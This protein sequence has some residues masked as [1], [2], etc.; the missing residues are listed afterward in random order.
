MALTEPSPGAERLFAILDGIGDRFYAVDRDWLVTFF[1]RAAESFLGLKRSDVLGRSLWE[2]FPELDGTEIEARYRR[3]MQSRSDE[4]FE[5]RSTVWPDHWLEIRVFATPE[6]LGMSARD[7]TSR[8]QAEDA[9]RRSE[10]KLR[11]ALAA[12][13]LG[14]WER[15]LQTGEFTTTELCKANLGLPADAEL[16]FDDLQRMRHPEDVGRVTSAIRNAIGEGEDYDVEYRV[17]W[18]DGSL[19]WLLA[20]GHAVY[21]GSGRPMRMVG[22]TLDVTN[23]KQAEAS[24][25][26]SE[27]FKTAILNASLDGIVTIDQDSRIVEWNTAAAAIFG[28]SRDMALGRDMTDLI[29]PVELRGAHRAGMGHYLSTGEGPVLGRRIEVE[30]IRSDGTRFPMELAISPIDTPGARHFTAFVRDITQSKQHEERL[31][32]SE[33]RLK[34]TYEHAFAGIGEVDLEGRF[35]RVNEQF[36][37]LTGYSQEEL[38]TRTLFAIT[39]PD[40]RA[41]DERLFRQQISGELD[42]YRLEKRYIHKN[43]DEVWIKLSA[44]AVR[45]GSG[46]MLYGI[47]VVDDISEQK[48]ADRHQKL[49]VNELNHRV[50]NSLA[51]VQSITSQTL[52]NAQGTGEARKALESR[53]QAMA[54]AHDVL[55]RENWESAELWEV[56]AE[57]VAPFSNVREDRLHLGGPRV[58]VPPRMALSLSMALQEL[59][60]NAA[61]YGALS[62]EQGQISISWH[63][64]TS[65]VRSRLRLRWEESG[66]PPVAMPSRRGFG[67]R[68]IERGLAQELD[69]EVRIEFAPSGVV[70]TVDAPLT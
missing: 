15:D 41:E 38:L 34:A 64:A 19:H 32:Q 25:Q 12:G 45:D 20:R 33:Q 35:T 57:A 70:C 37:L 59:A 44:S 51:T 65:S 30:A 4:F 3:V 24:L 31:R 66:G 22:V 10:E 18:P 56:V 53:I 6:G 54:R 26:A 63:V 60:T 21:D 55:T 36:C 46:A 42:A 11:A 1:N 49:L 58:R 48:K 52:R 68:L 7:I 50:K 14:A 27:L 17:I 28:Y 29:V 23:S 47:R 43:G 16:T 13:R 69:G 2:V 61:K 8:K 9:L 40:D 67:S 5:A 39:H 62:G